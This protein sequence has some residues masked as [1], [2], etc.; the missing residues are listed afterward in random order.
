MQS[1]ITRL[2]PHVLTVL[3]V[4]ALLMTPFEALACE[5]KGLTWVWRAHTGEVDLVGGDGVSNPY[6]GDTSCAS[7]LPILCLRKEGLPKPSYISSDFYSGWTGGRIRLTSPRLGSELTSRAVAD[8]IC[9][10]TFGPGW[11][12]G[13][14]HDGGG[15]WNWY[16]YGSVSTSGRFWVA[17][18]DQPA[19]PWNCSTPPPPPPS[20]LINGRVATSTGIGIGGVLVDA[21]GGR[22]TTTDSSGNYV[23]SGLPLGTY[24]LRA[25]RSGWTFGSSQFQNDNYTVVLA[26]AP[27]NQRTVNIRGWNSDPI[28]FV[29]GWTSNPGD[30]GSLPNEF[31]RQG[32]FVIARDLET[33]PAWTPPFAVN[34]RRVEAWIDEAK[35]VTGRGKVILYGHS[36]GGLVARA[37]LESGMYDGDVSQIFTYGSPHLGIPNLLALGCFILPRPDA[38]C[39]MTKPGMG[40]FNLTHFKRSGVDYHLIAGD[41]PMWTHKRVCFKIF[42]KKICILSIPW[43]DFTFRNGGGWAM[44]VLIPGADD[45][46]IQ[47]CSSSGMLGSNIDRYLTREVHTTLFG[48][49]D[50][51]TWDNGA[52]QEGFA[53]CSR[54]ILIDRNTV[55]CGARSWGPPL[56]CLGLGVASLTAADASREPS[57]TP[58]LGQLSRVGQGVLRPGGRMVRSVFIEGGATAFSATWGEGTVGFKLIDPTGQVIDPA[59]AASI[60][61]DPDDPEA[62]EV[63]E[64]DPDA[65]VYSGEPTQAGY[66][67]PAARP[68]TWQIVLEA[69][70]DVPAAGTSVTTAAGFDSSLLAGFST[71]RLSYDPGGTAT[72]RVSLSEPVLSADVQVTVLRSG[73][74]LETVQLKRISANEFESKYVVPGPSGYVALDWSITGQRTD[75]TAFE[76]GGREFVQVHST[77]LRLGS[78][79]TDRAIPRTDVAGLN[80]ALAVSLKVSSGYE[81]GE[82]GVFAELTAADGSVVARTVVSVP[83]RR[84]ENDVELRFRA[85]DIYQSK[86]DGP[87]TVRN[88]KLLDE[89]DAPVL[90]QDIPI[91]HTTKTYTYRSFAP[92]LVTPSVFLEGPFRVRAG[93]SVTLTAA[94][95]DPEGDVLGYAWDLDDD[96]SFEVSGQSVSFTTSSHD[97]AGLR[98]V[99]V[100]VADPQGNSAVAEAVVETFVPLANRS[101]VARCRDVTVPAACGLDDS[102][103]DG[104]YD[105][106]PGDSISC[107]QTPRGPY[108]VGSRQ[109]TLSC[110][111]AA[112]LSSSCEATVTVVEQEGPTLVLEG[113]S[114]MTLECGVDTWVDPGARAWDSCGP[115]PVHRYNSGDD[116]GDGI[117]GT[118][119]PDDYGPGPNTSAESSYGV[120]YIAWTA[121]GH[122]VSAARWVHVDD[123]TPPTLKLKGPAHMTHVCGSWWED[124]GVE[125]VDACYGNVAPTV[126]K[127][128]YVNGWAEGTY[129]VLYEVRDSG[130][131]S[132]PPVSRTV[133]VVDCPW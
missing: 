33:S 131:N 119:D 104:S 41:A 75:G 69:G 116:D 57:S 22:T 30:F 25:S 88:V 120:E 3:A 19:N 129:Q 61:G 54:R 26:P 87:Y 47:T 92:T 38:V 13:E 39:Q 48:S 126:V 9:A 76:R 24:T 1:G 35:Y 52:S 83:A 5:C 99:R 109:V 32:Y 36:M 79:H 80:S 71:D 68:G 93:E 55:T 4:V 107:V 70:S 53:Q 31:Q 77:A 108:E 28:V 113:D 21:G 103:D 117:P 96:G 89:R 111:D 105:P 60:Q 20:G 34:A 10:S 6:Q 27:N 127:T 97:P 125:A 114:Q 95:A 50:Y 45:A 130:G 14:F 11:A 121:A 8:G 18:N 46:F 17:I 56:S 84:G 51:H 37:Y 58:E 44:G 102:V 106:D 81:G 128:G 67:F 110:T 118:H 123:R 49:R 98:T 82:L 72:L 43:P 12:M 64:A 73:N 42:R 132:A 7:A 124:P 74:V 62:V 59:Y 15:G 94:G 91:A 40:L 101:P 86:V 90:S 29:H 78:G 66:F 65:V 122:T 23:L 115:L 2:R 16:A 85:E 63:V 133:D 112:G 100:R